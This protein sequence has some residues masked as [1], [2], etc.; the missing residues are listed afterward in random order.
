MFLDIALNLGFNLK[1]I[2]LPHEAQRGRSGRPQLTQER[3]AR[4][5]PA[6]P[7][8]PPPPAMLQPALASPK[9]YP[10]PFRAT[11]EESTPPSPVKSEA[12]L[13]SPPAPLPPPAD[14]PPL[15][16]PGLGESEDKLEPLATAGVDR[17]CEV[18]W[19]KPDGDDDELGDEEP[20]ALAAEPQ[21]EAESQEAL[22]ALLCRIGHPSHRWGQISM[23]R[24]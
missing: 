1:M 24:A 20:Q 13:P 18:D 15:P 14:S 6:Q 5:R 8:Y 9:E 2:L 23:R 17:V 4:R 19:A 16:A 21:A 11:K 3:N 22:E 7:P 10:S 12:S